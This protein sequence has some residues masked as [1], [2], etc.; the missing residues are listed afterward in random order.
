MSQDKFPIDDITKFQPMRIKC[1]RCRLEPE[2]RFALIMHDQMTVKQDSDKEHEVLAIF[3]QGDDECDGE[4]WA[5]PC[6]G[7]NGIVR[8]HN[9][10]R[11]LTTD[12]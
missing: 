12:N 9:V 11:T 5:F 8:K 1:S 10:L 4:A 3:C 2:W 7:D 6:Q